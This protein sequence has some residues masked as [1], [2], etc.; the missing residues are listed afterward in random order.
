V[1]VLVILGGILIF[2][3][4]HRQKIEMRD[5]YYTAILVQAPCID[6]VCPGFDQGRVRVLE[7]LSNSDVIERVSAQGD[8]L[9]GFA[10]MN[11]ESESGG[12]G[13]IYF[14]DDLSG[15][16]QTI[17][18]ISFRLY[19]LN[20]GTVL[21]ALGEPDKFLFISG[22]GM[23]L[24]VHA[25]LLYLNR[26][27][28]IVVDYVTRRPD[29]Q[30]LTTTTPVSS[31]EYFSPTNIQEHI[32]ETLNWYLFDSVAYDLDSS[33]TINDIILQVQTW[34]GLKAAPTP[35]ADFCPR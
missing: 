11:G 21:N 9:I 29:I 17:R 6:G 7:H 26:G 24:R 13:G 5:T 34:P 1:L 18:R 30:V 27:I 33:V 2:L 35:Y 22:C 25:K 19:G 3:Q 4:Q 8:A 12:T 23:G 15:N 31:I 10:F 32:Q 16:P 28:E 14:N 20:L